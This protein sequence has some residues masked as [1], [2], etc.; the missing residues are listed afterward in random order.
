MKKAFIVPANTITKMLFLAASTVMD[1]R[2]S[3][4]FI[5]VNNNDR[6]WWT[7]F[8]HEDSITISLGGSSVGFASF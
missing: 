4:K 5:F 2:S 6:K 1:S 8:F 3:E 7:S